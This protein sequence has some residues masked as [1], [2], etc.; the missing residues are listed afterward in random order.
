[1][2]HLEV[3]D[4]RRGEGSDDAIFCEQG[5][6]AAFAGVKIVQ[7]CLD[8]LLGNDFCRPSVDAAKNA[9]GRSDAEF[10]T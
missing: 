2:Q 4:G 3:V 5:V 9:K 10:I 6:R 8:P 7:P 1:M